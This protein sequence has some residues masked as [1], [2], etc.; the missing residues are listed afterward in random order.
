MYVVVFTNR[1]ECGKTCSA[2]WLFHTQYNYV[3]II[4]RFEI[5]RILTQISLHSALCCEI[6]SFFI[7]IEPKTCQPTKLFNVVVQLCLCVR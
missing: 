4:R 6:R 5:S 2:C 1:L 3:Y 7:L